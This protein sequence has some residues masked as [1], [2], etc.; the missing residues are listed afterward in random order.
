MNTDPPE[1]LLSRLSLVNGTGLTKFSGIVRRQRNNGE[2]QR[3][4]RAALLT[5]RTPIRKVTVRGGRVLVE[6][7][8][9]DVIVAPQRA[10]KHRVV[11][12]DPHGLEGRRIDTRDGIIRWW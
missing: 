7:D 10:R 3:A 4:V 11:V 8:V 6:L 2:L 12:R 5:S 1:G 9:E